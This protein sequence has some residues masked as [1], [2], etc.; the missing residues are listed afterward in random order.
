MKLED[1][2]KLNKERTQGKW[3]DI[4]G[5]LA[6]TN[7]DDFGG[8]SIGNG[9]NADFIEACSEIV[10]RMIK[11]LNA[12]KRERIYRNISCP[13]CNYSGEDDSGIP[14]YCWD[15]QNAAESADKAFA[16]LEQT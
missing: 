12:T 8:A 4:R 6:F 3:N 9:P 16:E 2:E 5:S 11:A 1:F 10:P 7:D 15:L 13:A 14:C